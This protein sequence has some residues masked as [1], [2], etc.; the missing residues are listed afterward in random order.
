MWFPSTLNR[1]VSLLLAILWSFFF[2]LGLHV[3][4]K[5][6]DYGLSFF[7]FYVS[8]AIL[9]Y[10]FFSFSTNKTEKSLFRFLGIKRKSG[11]T[12]ERLMSCISELL[13]WSVLISLSYVY[14]QYFGEN[15]FTP[16]RV[17][18]AVIVT[19]CSCLGIAF[20]ILRFILNCFGGRVFCMIASGVI[21]SIFA[22]FSVELGIASGKGLV[23]FY[24]VN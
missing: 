21:F 10:L 11:F 9:I 8:F 1:M 6:F 14:A 24:L 2:A 3:F 17:L 5:E 12:Y 13:V 20:S 19:L 15:G 22:K 7:G 4:P 18:I 16:F 23:E